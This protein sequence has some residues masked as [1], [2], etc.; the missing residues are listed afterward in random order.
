MWYQ[1][2]ET[3]AWLMEYLERSAFGIEIWSY[4]AGNHEAYEQ[5]KKAALERVGNG[6]NIVL[7]PR[8]PD[9][10]ILS[11]D[12]K[13]IE[14]GMAGADILD[15]ILREYFGWQIKRY[16]L[17]QILTS[18]TASTG[19][20][21]GVATIHLDTYLQIVRYD[22]TNLQETLTTDL[23]QPLLRYNWPQY[24]DIP[25]RFVVETESPDV[26]GKLRGWKSAYEMGLKIRAQDVAI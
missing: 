3:L 16:I 21:S 8:H 1:K 23:V 18:E 7:V 6:R 25:I 12:V 24:A 2:Q 13:R 9:S 14:P 10:D 22:A 20:G 11:S 5:T 26:E 4:P 19:L 15:R 17:G